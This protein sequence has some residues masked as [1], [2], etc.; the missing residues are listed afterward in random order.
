MAKVGKKWKILPGFRGEKPKTSLSGWVLD[1]LANRG[2]ITEQEISSYLDPRYEELLEPG[3]FLN[4]DKAV[5]RIAQAKENNEKV[6]VYGD[7]DVDGI[8][9]TALVLEILNKIGIQK[10]D[11][12]IPHREEEGYGL[13]DKA[14]GEIIDSGA[15]LIIAVDCGITSREIIDASSGKPSSTDVSQGK[16]DFIVCDH[17]EID[18]NKIPTKSVNIHPQL[19]KKEA[20]SQNLS[21][22]GMAFFLALAL[23]EK[24]PI[25]IPKGQE[26]W[27]LDL[28]A[29]ATICDVLPLTGQNRILA[30]FGLKVLAKS[31]R[32][33]LNALIHTASIN[34]NEINSYTV[35]FLLGPRLNAAGRLEHA[36]K[37]LELL[38][39]EDQAR[40]RIIAGELNK[41][42][43]E[44]QKMCDKILAEAKAEI[45]SSSKKDHEIYLLSNKNWPR[46]VVGI[47]ASKLSDAYSRPV[48]VFEHDGEEHHGSA[49]SVEGFDIT[50]ALTECEDCLLKYGGHA[51]AAGLSVSNKHFIIFSNKLL[52][53]ARNKIKKEELRPTITIDTKIKPEEISD[54]MLEQIHELEPFGYGNHTPVFMLENVSI[55]NLK[56]VGDSGQHIKF[57]V[58]SDRLQ[59]PGLKTENQKQNLT[60]KTSNQKPN[61]SAIWFNYDLDIKAQE[62]YDIVL[63]L[64]YNVWNNCKNIELRVID[65]KGTA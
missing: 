41:L 42:N 17:H 54:K 5:R 45:E 65:M 29:L 40:A 55:D 44:R 33:G 20:A 56:K 36:K 3:V 59:V 43:V 48:I 32:I 37:A 26:K 31:K 24:F 47:I 21:A 61:L 11:F 38:I 18:E 51:K 8:T 49:R 16:I 13:N 4:M 35:G 53:L 25:E 28:V 2:I 22:C 52:K 14:I 57:Q 1:V 10:Y 39:T 34:P 15:K 30:K 46:G 58:I 7:Y 19:M 60:S 50:A 6:V 63:T 64:R 27:F 23:Q 62:Q 12:Y 9:A